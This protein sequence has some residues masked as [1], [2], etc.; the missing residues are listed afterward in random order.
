MAG[1]T[2][3]CKEKQLT[4]SFI[5]PLNLYKQFKQQYKL[6][7]FKNFLNPLKRFFSSNLNKNCGEIF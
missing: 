4:A 1:S 7:I 2:E 3:P 6:R 5:A